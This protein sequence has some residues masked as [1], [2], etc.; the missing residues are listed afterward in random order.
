MA[1]RKKLS[2]GLYSTGGYSTFTDKEWNAVTDVASKLACGWG[3]EE[4][5][6]GY[7]TAVMDC[8]LYVSPT[9]VKPY[10]NAIQEAGCEWGRMLPGNKRLD[11]ADLFK[12]RETCDFAEWQVD[13][14]PIGQSLKNGDWEKAQAAHFRSVADHLTRQ[15]KRM[16]R[17]A[18]RYDRLLAKKP[19]TRPM[20][21]A[22]K[23]ELNARGERI[24]REVL[25][26][27]IAPFIRR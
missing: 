7:I 13:E 14:R 19:I 6:E 18:K 20:N 22:E 27:E 11:F 17:E 5:W 16:E 24:A 10:F 1:R 2:S 3:H 26:A 9:G 15:A 23:A 21:E 4:F 12:T 8:T 25:L